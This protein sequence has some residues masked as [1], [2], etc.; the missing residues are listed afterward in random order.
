MNIYSAILVARNWDLSAGASYG[1]GAI[2]AYG[3]ALVCRASAGDLR[4]LAFPDRTKGHHDPVSLAFWCA[5]DGYS[6]ARSVTC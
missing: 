5:I 1:Q 2:D 3:R 6:N 4:L